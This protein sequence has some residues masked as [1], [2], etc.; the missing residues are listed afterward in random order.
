M[1]SVCIYQRFMPPDPSGAGK[2]ALT[3]ARVVKAEGWDVVFLTDGTPNS[4]R[5][6]QIEGFPLH[7]VRPPPPDPSYPQLLAYWSRVGAR[8]LALRRRFDVLHVHSAEF[9]QSA[10]VPMARLLG[11]PV[12]VRSSISG[13]FAGL[14]TSRS[15]R[16]QRRMLQ[17]AGAFV[18][19]SRRLEEEFGLSG[20][21]VSRLHR[22][23]NGVD[24]NIDHPV[25]AETKERLRKDLSLPSRGRILVYHGVFIAR[26]SL[27]WLIP[28]LAEPLARLDLTLVLVGGPARED[29]QTGYMRHLLEEVARSPVRDRI[30]LRER[31]PAVHRYLQA[32]DGYVLPSTSEGLPNA[33]IEAMAS[34]LVPIATRTGGAEDVIEHGES[35]FLFEPRDASTFLESLEAAFGPGDERRAERIGKA[36]AE[37]VQ[38]HFSISVTGHMYVDTYRRLHYEGKKEV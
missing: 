11:K 5:D 22:I 20:L 8:L 23:P 10:A 14:G 32:S 21:P 38:S 25:A 34:G 15:G 31:D 30:I 16:V 6:E 18:V 2:Q 26:K 7:R 17:G 3:L 4:G 35:G 33:L 13:E 1:P 36:A 12:L 27:D 28:V 9:S 24:T 29:S 37:R 19:L